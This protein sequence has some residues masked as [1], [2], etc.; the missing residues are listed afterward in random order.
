MIVFT[1]SKEVLNGKSARPLK[2]EVRRGGVSFLA[3]MQKRKEGRKERKS[4]AGKWVKRVQSIQDR[5]GGGVLL[6]FKC[7]DEP[8]LADC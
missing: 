1:Q 2:K 7:C 8:E 6:L 4:F 5:T 3:C